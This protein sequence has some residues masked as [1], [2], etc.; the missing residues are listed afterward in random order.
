[1]LAREVPVRPGLETRVD[2]Y[3]LWPY[4]RKLL[5][6][7]ADGAAALA[8]DL[9]D[10][11]LLVRLA[12]PAFDFSQ[13]APDGSD[14][15]FSAAD[16]TPLPREIENWDAAAGTAAVWVRLDTLRAGQAGQSI[17]MHWGPSPAAGPMRPRPVFD[18]AAGFAA[19]WHLGEEAADTVANGLYKDATGAGSDGDDRIASRSRAGVIGY[20]HGLDSGDYIV[21]PRPSDD[22]RI[23]GSFTL[24]AWIRTDGKKDANTS[25]DLI[26]MGDNYGLRL[27]TDSVLIV[28]YWPP[29]PPP[30]AQNPWYYLNAKAPGI[31]DGRWHLATAVFD[32]LSLRLYYDGKELGSAP[33]ADRVG[34]QFPLNA[35]LGRHGKG[36][37]GFEYAGDLDEVRVHSVAR[38]SEW[39]KMEFENQKPGSDFPAWGP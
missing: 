26:S 12:A 8:H 19:V 32:G 33:A 15:R 4:S 11:P 39:A 24:S 36:Q 21:S 31:L 27:S 6:N 35:T 2:A 16:G 9:R 22:L 37:R 20:G 7:T 3:A 5:L 38:D 25:Q 30:A 17:T 28:W 13:A 29:K 14:L 18:T 1:V 34:L 10:F 23:S